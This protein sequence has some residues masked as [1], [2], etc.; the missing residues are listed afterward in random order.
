MT[1]RKPMLVYLDEDVRERLRRLAFNERVP[2]AMLIRRAVDQYLKGLP[3]K[4][5]RR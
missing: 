4:A 5:V 1:K 2:M 3:R